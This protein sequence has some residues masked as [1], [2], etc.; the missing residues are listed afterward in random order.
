MTEQKF[1][2]VMELIDL[3]SNIIPEGDYLE[4]CNLLRDVRQESIQQNQPPPTRRDEQIMRHELLL[5]NRDLMHA[6]YRQNNYMTHGSATELSNS[7]QNDINT[8]V[9]MYRSGNNN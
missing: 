7:I 3:N 1:I 2:R 5:M 9:N 8:L 6:L 4:L